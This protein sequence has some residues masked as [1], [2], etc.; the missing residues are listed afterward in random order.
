MKFDLTMLLL[1]ISLICFIV[2]TLEYG[3]QPRWNRMIA[4][5]FV[6]LVVVLLW[7]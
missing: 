3:N 1:I 7:R 2:A 5:G 6:F 4:A